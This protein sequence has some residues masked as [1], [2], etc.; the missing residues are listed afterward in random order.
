MEGQC[1]P[2]QLVLSDTLYNDPMVKALF[3]D[4]NIKIVEDHV[5]VKGIEE[6]L[7]IHRVICN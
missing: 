1:K 3:A 4:G 5:K 2:G 6:T 7:P